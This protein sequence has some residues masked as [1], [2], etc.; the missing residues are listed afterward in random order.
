MLEPGNYF[1]EM[2]LFTGEPRTADVYALEEVEVLEIRKAAIEPLMHDN[3]RLAEAISQRVA[4][5]QAELIAHTRN[6][7]EEEKQ[8]QSA[9]ILRRVKRFFSLG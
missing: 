2:A 5:R 3:T 8:Q 4:E 7:P 1:G 9:N 6:V